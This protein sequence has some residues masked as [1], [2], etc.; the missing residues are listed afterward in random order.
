MQYTLQI[1]ILNNMRDWLWTPLANNVTKHLHLA[2][3][4]T[5]RQKPARQYIQE[6]EHKKFNLALIGAIKY[7]HIT[8]CSTYVL[9]TK[10]HLKLT[11]SNIDVVLQVRFVVH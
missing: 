4:I 6:P 1:C 8:M 11:E 5:H 3:R 10:L 2:G 7:V 9:L